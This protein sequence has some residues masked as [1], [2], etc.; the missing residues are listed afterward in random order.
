MIGMFKNEFFSRQTDQEELNSN[1]EPDRE[2]ETV[3]ARNQT[4]CL[5]LSRS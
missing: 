5:A 4:D 3:I 1:Y 2:F